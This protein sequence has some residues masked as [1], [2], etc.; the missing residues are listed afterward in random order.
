LHRLA[1]VV[2]Q[3]AQHASKVDHFTGREPHRPLRAGIEGDQPSLDVAQQHPLPHRVEHG[4]GAGLA[5]GERR[6]RLGKTFLR[7]QQRMPYRQ[8]Q[9]GQQQ[10]RAN[11]LELDQPIDAVGRFHLDG[12]DHFIHRRHIA[13][14]EKCEAHNQ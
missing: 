11:R 6:H 8:A 3:P 12:I 14:L 1:P 2:E 10:D 5:L 7:R 4:A 9:R 13:P